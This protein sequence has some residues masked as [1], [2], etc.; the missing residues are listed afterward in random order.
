MN[1]PTPFIRPPITSEPLALVR[2]VS[3]GDVVWN[4]PDRPT[5]KA[6]PLQVRPPLADVAALAAERRRDL[7]AA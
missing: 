1:F 7:T 6:P 2:V 5:F 3:R 4:Q